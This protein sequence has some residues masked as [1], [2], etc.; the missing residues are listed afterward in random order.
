MAI[1]TVKH[2]THILMAVLWSY[3]LWVW[4]WQL[5]LHLLKD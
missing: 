1:Y 4:R 2:K 5:C 3:I